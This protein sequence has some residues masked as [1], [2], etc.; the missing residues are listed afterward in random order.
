MCITYLGNFQQAATSLPAQTLFPKLIQCQQCRLAHNLLEVPQV[1]LRCGSTETHHYQLTLQ[2]L[3]HLTVGCL[4]GEEGLCMPLEWVTE[5]CTRKHKH[6]QLGDPEA[7]HKPSCA[8]LSPE[9]SPG[10]LLMRGSRVRE[11]LEGTEKWLQRVD[12]SG[13]AWREDRYRNRVLTDTQHQ[14]LM[15][16]PHVDNFKFFSI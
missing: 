6:L 4:M 7:A 16:Y 1:S 15:L 9:P 5:P 8:S 10:P 3:F 12:T 13:S 11:T 14:G 2:C